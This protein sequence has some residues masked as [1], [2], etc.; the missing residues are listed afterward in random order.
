MYAR[1]RCI[2]VYITRANTH[3]VTVRIQVSNSRWWG[4]RPE[5]RTEGLPGTF[6]L[7]WLHTVSAKPVTTINKRAPRR[8][9]TAASPVSHFSILCQCY[10][11]WCWG[12]LGEGRRQKNEQ[13]VVDARPKQWMSVLTNA[14]LQAG[15]PHRSKTYNT[16]PHVH[17]AQNPSYGECADYPTR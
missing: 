1:T 4:V 8:Q 2:N 9:R 3:T 7:V 14:Y 11:G 16:S 13:R 6:G 10:A 15:S 17:P 5:C 12:R